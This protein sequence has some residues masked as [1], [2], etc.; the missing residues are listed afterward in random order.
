MIIYTANE[1][2][3]ML[4]D[5]S[6]QGMTPL[7][8]LPVG[9]MFYDFEEIEN[10]NKISNFELWNYKKSKWEIAMFWSR[11]G[12]YDFR[13]DAYY[14]GHFGLTI[15]GK[16]FPDFLFSDGNE[17]ANLLYNSCLRSH[18][19]SLSNCDGNPFGDFYTIESASDVPDGNIKQSIFNCMIEMLLFKKYYQT[20]EM[21][22]QRL[23]ID[24]V[25]NKW[26][27]GIVTLYLKRCMENP[28]WKLNIIPH[29]DIKFC[30]ADEFISVINK[31]A[32]KNPSAYE[33]QIEY[34]EFLTK[35]RTALGIDPTDK[36]K[37]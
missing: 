9:E 33:I 25:I 1:L 16:D 32:L 34:G 17:F 23:F 18:F 19:Q 5:D 24:T 21:D 6:S 22:W 20:F 8:K 26:N 11:Q 10:L 27:C 36:F 30:R 12:L 14:E 7:A 37:L 29:V 2:Y 35:M 4:D 3:Q 31:Y 15:H 13:V 28:N